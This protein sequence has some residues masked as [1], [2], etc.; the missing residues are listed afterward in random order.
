L[1]ESISD[2]AGST[3][4]RSAPT[5]EINRESDS[6]DDAGLRDASRVHDGLD[7]ESVGDVYQGT[8]GVC[9]DPATRYDAEAVQESVGPIVAMRPTTV[10]SGGLDRSRGTGLLLAGGSRADTIESG[11]M[12]GDSAGRQLDGPVPRT[13]DGV[14]SQVERLSRG[15]NQQIN[16]IEDEEETRSES[17]KTGVDVGSDF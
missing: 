9:P 13:I 15:L 3:V 8:Q 12:V 2:A 4:G 6:F 10:K 16:F 1:G 5:G 14:G 11:S 17:L 7:E